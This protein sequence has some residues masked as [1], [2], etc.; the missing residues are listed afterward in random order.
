MRA[1]FQHT[2]LSVALLAVSSFATRAQ[3][4]EYNPEVDAAKQAELEARL[5]QA[6]KEGP[7]LEGQPADLGGPVQRMDPE[8]REKF[9]QMFKEYDANGDGRLDEAERAAAKEGIKERLRNDPAVRAKV[10]EKFDANGNG[11]LDPEEQ[12][13]AQAKMDELR[14][15]FEERKGDMRQKFM[16][17]LENNPEMKAK[18]L[19]KFDANGNGAMDEAEWAA[20]REAFQARHAEG[21]KARPGPANPQRP[22]VDNNF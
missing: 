8:R 12:A 19:E 5:R 4:L 17:R 7:L 3:D 15:R 10:L 18:L 22:A 13:E 9:K 20:A 2:L 6:A 11:R 16:A 14:G 1:G 21:R